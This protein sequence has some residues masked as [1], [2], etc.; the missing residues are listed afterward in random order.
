MILQSPESQ[1]ADVQAKHHQRHRPVNQECAAR[2][3]PTILDSTHTTRS[4]TNEN[5]VKPDR[6]CIDMFMIGVNAD[7]VL[8]WRL[9]DIVFCVWKG[10]K[11]PQ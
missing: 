4:L 11:M 1:A 9:L 3:Q 7:L 6:V 2:V 10:G 8:Q 5:I